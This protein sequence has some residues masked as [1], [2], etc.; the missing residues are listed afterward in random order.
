MVLRPNYWTFRNLWSA[1]DS[2]SELSKTAKTSSNVEST[3]RVNRIAF[4]GLFILWLES[5]EGDNS[6][7]TSLDFNSNM[8]RSDTRLTE[9]ETYFALVGLLQT[10]KEDTTMRTHLGDDGGK[11]VLSSGVVSWSSTIISIVL[12]CTTKRSKLTR[13]Q[14]PTYLDTCRTSSA[15]QNKR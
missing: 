15:V 11:R 9:R 12:F 13:F 3:L 1:V 10:I 8:V 2:V 7:S 6:V 5:T 4:D 14:W